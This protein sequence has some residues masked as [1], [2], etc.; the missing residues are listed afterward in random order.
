M[1]EQASI[2]LRERLTA[3]DNQKGSNLNLHHADPMRPR[4]SPVDGFDL[5][6]FLALNVV[7]IGAMWIRHGNLATLDVPGGALSA[8]GDVTALYGT[9]AI[10]VLLVL[11][12][13]VP[14]IERRY[15]MDRLNLWHRW[16][17][18]AATVLLLGHAILTTLG[19]AAGLEGGAWAQ[20]LDFVNGHQWMLSAIIGLL[21]L[22]AIAG[23][24]LKFARR[25]LSYETWWFIHV[26]AYLAVALSFMH[27]IVAGVDFV[28]DPWARWYWIALYAVTGVFLLGFR[29]ITPIWRMQHHRLRVSEV[30]REAPNVLTI[31]LSG[32][33]LSRLRVEA[34][35]FFILRF[36][37]GD[38]W[39]KA[40]PFSLSAKPDGHTLRFTVKQ[41]GDDTQAMERLPVGTR[42]MAEGPYGTFTTA[43]AA[44]R[45]ILLIGGGIG[46][47]PIRSMYED[48][49][50]RPG[51]VDLLYR[52]RTRA[53]AALL[54]ELE[55]IHQRRGYG[56]E[57]S[58]SATAGTNSKDDPLRTEALL[59][60]YPDIAQ[61]DVF[62]CGPP[63]LLA[64]AQRGLRSAGVSSDQIHLERFSY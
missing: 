9:A 64:S 32:R 44:K 41:V 24:S 22:M 11:V 62:V 21:L 15:G 50:R 42:V 38:S 47:S 58:F 33:K 53:D 31:V 30:R 52:T 14:W 17:G 6:W 60:R 59:A 7:L 36:L 63:S 8:A 2:M 13:R 56:F 40:H 5:G 16:T 18:F 51:E 19:Y 57:V 25:R 39:W 48:L 34:G 46:I 43:L 35:Q 61:R 45:R 26:Y 10:L 29:W 1:P 37:R 28:D 12:A 3:P 49:D 23:T 54:G 27:Q 55:E 4:R 20:L